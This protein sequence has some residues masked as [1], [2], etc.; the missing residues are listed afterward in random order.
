M[1]FFQRQF[2]IRKQQ[3]NNNRFLTAIAFFCILRARNP[4]VYLLYSYLFDEK[5]HLRMHELM[6][7]SGVQS[8]E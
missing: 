5:M 3:N 7:S 6:I 8:A 2:L 4:T 1:P